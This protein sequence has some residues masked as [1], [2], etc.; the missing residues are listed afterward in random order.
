MSGN[1]FQNPAFQNLSPEKLQFLM[2]FQQMAKPSSM[3]DA[4]PFVMESLKQAQSKGIRFSNDESSLLIEI[5][6]QNMS[7]QEQKKADMI[8]NMMKIRQKK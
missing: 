6:K 1:I 4:A 7:P 2:E 3:K 8:L 5:L